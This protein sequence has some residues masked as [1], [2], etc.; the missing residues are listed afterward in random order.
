[1][2]IRIALLLSLLVFA[3]PVFSQDAVP[4]TKPTK[5]ADIPETG[6]LTG[7]AFLITKAGDLKP[8]RLA[9]VAL[10]WFPVARD[11]ETS[12]S[13]GMEY[14]RNSVKQMQHVF[15]TIKDGHAFGEDACRTELA[16]YI[17]ALTDT[18][19]WIAA[20][21]KSDFNKK[22]Q[23]DEEGRFKITGIPAGRYNLVVTGYAGVNDAFWEQEEVVITAGQ[24]TSVKLSSPTKSCLTQ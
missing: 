4:H 2:K 9:V 12:N 3:N 15:E 18:V 14:R 7:Y 13:A 16:G 17:V 22:I 20:Q 21:R 1:M 6:E 10:L 19:K 24:T 11:A 5:K 8:A 23:A